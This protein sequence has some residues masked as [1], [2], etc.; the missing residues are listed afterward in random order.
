MEKFYEAKIVLAFQAFCIRF[1]VC[2]SYK[3]VIINIYFHY[4]PGVESFFLLYISNYKHGHISLHQSTV[5]NILWVF[6]RDL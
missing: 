6:R 1:I 2:L 4:V 5:T 3:V